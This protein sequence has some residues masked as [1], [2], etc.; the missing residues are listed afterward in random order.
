MHFVW[1]SAFLSW[2]IVDF[3]AK[4]QKKVV[5]GNGFGKINAIRPKIKDR[6]AYCPMS[7]LNL[8]VRQLPLRHWGHNGVVGYPL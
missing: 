4:L 7:L 6:Q 5:T 1:E 8:G 3:S 2:H